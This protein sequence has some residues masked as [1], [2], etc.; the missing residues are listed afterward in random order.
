LQIFSQ[1]FYKGALVL[2]TNLGI[3]AYAVDY[4]YQIIG[5]NITSD[6]KSG[7]ASGTLNVGLEYGLNKWFG[8]GLFSKFDNYITKYDS[9]TMAKPNVGG[10]ELALMLNAHIV[11]IN[12]FDLPIG[13]N[14]GYSHLNYQNSTYTL[15]GNGSYFDLH[16]NPRFYI[17]KFGFNLNIAIPFVHYNNLTSN[18]STFNQYVL[19]DWKGAG[20][21][22]GLGIQYRFFSAK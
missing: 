3:D 13:F 7:A 11:H 2:N 19:A 18:N 12:H 14:I 15:Y 17:K 6:K 8:I 22:L 9:V 1:S 4:H 10:L 5:T 16:I 20:L 21:G